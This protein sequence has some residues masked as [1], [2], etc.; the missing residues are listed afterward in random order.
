MKIRYA[1]TTE[2]PILKNIWLKCFEDKSEYIDSFLSFKKYWKALIVEHDNSI[3][4]MLFIIPTTDNFWYLYAIATL[5]QQRRKGFMSK[6][7]NE[8]FQR[9][10]KLQKKGLLL[11]PADNQLRKYYER[12][13]FRV[14]STLKKTIL[15]PICSSCEIKEKRLS[16]SEINKIRKK[17]FTN[18]SAINW[19]NKHIELLKQTLNIYGGEIITFKYKNAL[20]YIVVE[21]QIHLIVKEIAICNTSI[22]KALLQEITNFL[23]EKYKRSEKVIF[24]LKEDSSFGESFPFAMIKSSLPLPITNNYFNLA[25][26]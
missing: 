23:N 1:K 25:L 4:S 7:L 2:I 11:V 12:L 18:T 13:S 6:L 5:P 16:F 24:Y 9:A 20:G 22:T 10:I 26:D 3:T 15:Y 19:K 8:A 17:F 21:E 14:F